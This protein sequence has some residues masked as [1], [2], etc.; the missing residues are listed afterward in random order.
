VRAARQTGGAYLTVTDQEIL[1]AIA[2]LGPSGI[3]VEPAGAA[4]YAGFLKAIK[5]G[6][7]HPDDPILVLSTGNGLKDIRAAMQAVIEA[8][9]IEP[10]MQALMKHLGK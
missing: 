6:V 10:S 4:A 9:V 2:E 1:K 3:F 7:V 5:Q 8:P